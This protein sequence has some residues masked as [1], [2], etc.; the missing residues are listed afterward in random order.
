MAGVMSR[1]RA[2]LPKEIGLPA[3]KVTDYLDDIPG[4]TK[5]NVL[6]F[7]LED[8]CAVAVRP[9]GTEPKVKTYVMAAGDSEN[10]AEEHLA[11]IREAVGELLKA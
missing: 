7:D 3:V 4:F 8:G 5:S 10:Q 9:S 6:F 2:D 1:I 11:A